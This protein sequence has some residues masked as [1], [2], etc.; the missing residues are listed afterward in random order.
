MDLDILSFIDSLDIRNHLK[1]QQ[2]QFGTP[3]AAFLVWCCRS[4]TLREKFLAWNRIIQTM[5]DCGM[6]GRYN[7]EQI[8]DFHM[9]LNQYMD[10]QKRQFESFKNPAGCVYFS[11]FCYCN[12]AER[13]DKFSFGPFS[14]YEKCLN[15]ACLE[16]GKEQADYGND[17]RGI[18]ITR[19]VVDG[20]DA[21]SGIQSEDLCFVNLK[22]DPTEIHCKYLNESD[23]EIGT[24]FDG[25]W[26]DFPT[27]FHAGDIVCSVKDRSRPFVLT[28]ISTWD[29]TKVREEHYEHIALERGNGWISGRNKKISRLRVKGDTSDMSACGF[30]I[31]SDLTGESS[32]IWKDT[33]PICSYLDLVYYKE[34]L[35]GMN[36]LLKPLSEFIKGNIGIELLLNACSLLYQKNDYRSQLKDFIGMY[37]ERTFESIGF[38]IPEMNE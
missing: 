13:R 23:Q 5:P 20:A 9:F 7:M 1:D 32:W 19:R 12:S 8:P 34:P 30:G 37:S 6:T 29:E 36:C 2:Y 24:A 35:S 26:F 28:E 11:D 21:E 22:G 25:M 17:A 27:P 14:T 38:H 10:L 4:K 33:F 3:E 16:A 18:L 15:A 31:G